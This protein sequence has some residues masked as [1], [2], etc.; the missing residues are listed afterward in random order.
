MFKL[1]QKET[2]RYATQQINIK[3]QEGSLKPK[4]VFA[5]W[6]TASLLEIKK[7]FSVIIHISMLRM[8]SVQDY[9]SS[10]PIIH[11]PHAASVGKSRDRFLALLT[12]LYLNNNNAKAARGQPDYDPLFKIWPIIDTLVTK[13]QHI[14]TPVEQL[15]IDEALCPFRGHIFFHVYIKGK[16]YK[17][18]IKMF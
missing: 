12:M 7:F 1:I 8:S 15:T 6:N 17:Y 10:R 3:K 16:P 5:Q 9:W 14:Y 11:T 4:S 13:F 2:N 18:G